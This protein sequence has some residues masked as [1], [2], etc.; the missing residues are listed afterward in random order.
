MPTRPGANG[1]ERCA[2]GSDTRTGRGSTSHEIPGPRGSIWML[3]EDGPG[4]SM[5]AYT[6]LWEGATAGGAAGECARR[7]A[8]RH[9]GRIDVWQ[10]LVR[11]SLE[12]SF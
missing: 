3:I 8:E 11:E 4:A 2:S 5:R 10:A 12:P 9:G 1:A 7:L 6:L